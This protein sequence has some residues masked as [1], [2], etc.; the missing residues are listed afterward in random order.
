MPALIGFARWPL[1]GLLA[2][3]TACAPS[4]DAPLADR[5]AHAAP[6]LSREVLD[7]A[8]SA[9]AC[10]QARGE[11]DGHALA[12]ID[13]TRPSVLQ[14]LWLFDLDTGDV[15][16]MLVAHGEATGGLWATD[17]SNTPDS[18]Q[19]SLGLFRGAEVY[20][21]DHGRSLRLD[22][23]E[24]GFNDAARAREIVVHG[25]DYVSYGFILRNGRL[26]RSWGCPAVPTD[27]ADA[28]VTALADGGALFAWGERP[29][30]EGGVCR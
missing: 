13:Y 6:S 7:A 10:A 18:H 9:T 15:R 26:G 21:G 19:T 27:E 17:F 22:G 5:L 24:P 23:L 20:E 11:V 8:L 12:V 30:W 25:A 16:R 14:R 2:A 3:L 1:T 28:L 29:G 4:P